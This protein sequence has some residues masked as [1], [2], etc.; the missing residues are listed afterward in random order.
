MRAALLTPKPEFESLASR[1]G[2]D[3][4]V[5][6]ILGRDV[7]QFALREPL[8]I[9][10]GGAYFSFETR[11]NS[12]GHEP[13]LAFEGVGTGYFGTSF[14]GGTAGFLRS[15]GD[16]PL[17]A[18]STDPQSPPPAVD[19]S[20]GAVW[21]SM[22]SP[23]GRDEHRRIAVPDA[24]SR[25]SGR[26]KA[27]LGCTYLVRAILPGEHDHAVA[28][29]T[30]ERDAHGYTLVFRIVKRFPMAKTRHRPAPTPLSHEI[31]P[32]LRGLSVKDLL[33][34]PTNLRRDGDASLLR[35]PDEEVARTRKIANDESA[36][37][38]KILPRGRYGAITSPR[39]GGAYL[40][41]TT[42]SNDYD[43][44][45]TI[46]YQADG[47]YSGFYGGTAG[48]VVDLGAVSLREAESIVRGD[49]TIS[50][51]FD[52]ELSTVPVKERSSF[53]SDELS[54]FGRPEWIYVAKAEVGHTYLVRKASD[55]DDEP[56]VLGFFQYVARDEH[57]AAT[58]AWRVAR[59]DGN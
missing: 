42:G 7:W 56:S 28:F 57:G 29:R 8:A 16:L 9:P 18:L 54:R 38:S 41:F 12:Y 44:Q 22:L 49:S 45:P 19:A 3:G 15:L 58:L 53:L 47:F 39:G 33:A 26:A 30:V 37:V 21:S 6:R 51:L 5:A 52:L 46:G 36:R 17:E 43:E 32:E 23:I 25:V 24:L 4:G 2:E 11:S 20:I 48:V 13:D 1:W 10:G 27:E 50:R 55:H 14:Y 31:A 34:R 59:T 40:S 35:V